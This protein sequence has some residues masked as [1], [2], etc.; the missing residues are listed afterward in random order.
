[1]SDPK[2]LF[3]GQTLKEFQI[4]IQLYRYFQIQFQILVK[5]YLFYKA[6][7]KK[8]KNPLEA[9]AI[10]TAVLFSHILKVFKYLLTSRFYIFDMMDLDPKF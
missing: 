6:K 7:G 4:P 3:P 10:G 5:I 2:T 9:L 8:L 1:M